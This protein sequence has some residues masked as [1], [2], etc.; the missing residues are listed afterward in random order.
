MLLNQSEQHF[1]VVHE[2]KKPYNYKICD[3]TF[4]KSVGIVLEIHTRNW[5]SFWYPHRIFSW[6][7][8]PYARAINLVTTLDLVTVFWENKSVTKSRFHC[9]S[10]FQINNSVL[11]L[12]VSWSWVKTE[13]TLR[14]IVWKK[15]KAIPI[16]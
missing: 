14:V 4:E 12:L 13:T 16:F 8:A 9:M 6:L 2:W 1:V 10:F 7:I 11:W 5:S 15:G 3:K